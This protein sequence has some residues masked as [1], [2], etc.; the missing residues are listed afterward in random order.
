V[1]YLCAVTPETVVCVAAVVRN[2]DRIL[3]VR[4][5]PGHSLEGQWT[6]PW[7]RLEAAESPAAAAVRE[8]R[9]EGGIHAAVEGLLGVHAFF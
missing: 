8:A 1:G 5:A 7:G 6:V 4:Q 9:E 3:L 2:A